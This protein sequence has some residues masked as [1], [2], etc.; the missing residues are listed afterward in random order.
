KPLVVL[1]DWQ[2]GKAKQLR[3]RENFQGTTW[4][5]VFHPTGFLV[6]V[7]AGNGGAL[8]FW[9]PDQA[10]DFFTLKLPTNARDVDLHRDGQRLTVAFADG[11]VRVYDMA[12]KK[13]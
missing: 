13:P 2:T 4:G 7:G 10:Q 5:V 1:F 12:P 3:P 11:A 6:G 9:K 8:W